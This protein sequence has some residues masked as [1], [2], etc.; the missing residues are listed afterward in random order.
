MSKIK[1]S[2][3]KAA[4]NKMDLA[5]CRML[6]S[7]PDL[8]T[9]HEFSGDMDADDVAAIAATHSAADALIDAVE[10]VLESL[11]CEVRPDQPLPADFIE[12]L[13]ANHERMKQALAKF[14]AE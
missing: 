4:R 5:T 13:L 10:A 14:E 11:A 7:K 1:L 9:F 8:Y 6:S 12:Q 2:E 3:L